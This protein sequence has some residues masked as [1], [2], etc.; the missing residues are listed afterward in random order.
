MKQN[1]DTPIENFPKITST[2]WKPDTISISHSMVQC[3]SPGKFSAQNGSD[4]V[5]LHFGL[6]GNCVSFTMF[7]PT[8]GLPDIPKNYIHLTHQLEENNTGT[9]VRTIQ[10]DFLTVDNGKKRYEES[11]KGWEM[12]I[13]LM[14]KTLK[15]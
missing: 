10:G 4:S 2:Q 8:M 5:R 15:G 11:L 13:P 6:K 9:L 14:K 7:D 1:S 12:V 3:K